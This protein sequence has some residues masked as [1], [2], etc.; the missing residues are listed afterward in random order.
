MAEFARLTGAPERLARLVGETTLTGDAADPYYEQVLFALRD[1]GMT[2]PARSDAPSVYTSYGPD[3]FADY[4]VDRAGY[5]VLGT[6]PTLRWLDWLDDE[7]VTVVFGGD[8]GG[9]LIQWAEIRGTD[10][11]VLADP[12]PTD[13]AVELVDLGMPAA[14]DDDGRF[15][16]DGDPAPTR[17]ETDAETLE[18]LVSAADIV[19]G[20]GVP[21][22]VVDGQF[23]LAVS[24]D[25]MDGTG[26]LSA[27]SV[28]GPDCRNWYGPELGAI[29]RTLDGPVTLE[30]LPG[31][32]LAVVQETATAT[33]RYVLSERV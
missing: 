2:A 5:V 23:R 32:P 24:G 11:R 9:Q 19:D 15:A 6:V 20:D 22:V 8:S 4:E 25:V 27:R 17:V 10:H 30:I 13:V 33:R 16:P 7:E 1:D 18:R 31:G 28:T 14:F 29:S 26:T 3:H 21:V 12:L